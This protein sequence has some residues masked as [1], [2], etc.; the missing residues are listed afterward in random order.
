MRGGE[1][2]RREVR[3]GNS[4]CCHCSK[5]R[6]NGESPAR[7]EVRHGGKV[8]EGR[9]EGGNRRIEGGNRRTRR[10]ERRE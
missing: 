10:E 2:R 5:K 3:E 6:R 4:R 8:V 7:L 9:I 1:R